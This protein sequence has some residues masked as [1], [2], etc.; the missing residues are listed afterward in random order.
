MHLCESHFDEFVLRRI[1]KEIR[2][3]LDLKNTKNI[4]VA[5]SG[6][7]DSGV[8]LYALARIL[9]KIP[10]V[11]LTAV[12]V[13]EGIE[14]YRPPSLAAAVSVCEMV[15]VPH[16]V[17]SFRE[18]F[19]ITLDEAAA[20]S[21]PLTPCSY[22]GVW[23]KKCLNMAASDMGADVLVTGHNLDDTAQ[24]VAMN[25]FKAEVDRL[26]RMGPHKRA[27]PGLVPRAMPLR[28]IPE[29]EIYL[30]ARINNIP[31]ELDICPYSVT[32]HRGVFRDIVNMVEK[33]TPG[34]RHRLLNS[35]QTIYRALADDKLPV[36]LTECARCGEPSSSPVC[37]AC[38]MEKEVKRRLGQRE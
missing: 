28:T 35:Y 26:V 31:H 24:S 12:S 30:W 5:V 21:S 9:G 3:Q 17:V 27:I 14:G 6:G 13:D 34:T 7:K 15:G 19:G 37:K 25:I 16:K 2:L 36:E 10:S 38:E 20:V 32:A 4:A 33:D 22:C 29:K 1:K 11:N 8:V 23:R 18:H